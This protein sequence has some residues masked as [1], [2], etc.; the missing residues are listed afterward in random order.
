MNEIGD[1]G[2]GGLAHASPDSNEPPRKVSRLLLLWPFAGFLGLVTAIVTYSPLDDTLCWI[3]GSIPCLAIY[4]LIN[5]A[6]RKV[7]GGD[8]VPSFFP[9]TIWLAT[10]CLFV[11]VVLFANGALDRSPVEQHRETVTRT[12]LEHGRHGS[13]YYSLEMTSWRP[14]HAH[15]KVGVSKSK[16]L[17]FKVGDPVI[18][19]T[20]KGTLGIPLL[21]S[22][23][24]PN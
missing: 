10:G 24:W 6:W 2:I 12:I 21:V 23:H 4:T 9:R 7:R 17:D 19:E 18:V 16:Y 8:D 11:P 13:I 5:I 15:E 3:A 1:S 22:V 14:K 20:R